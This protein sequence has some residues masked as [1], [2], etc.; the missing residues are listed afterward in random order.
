MW[1]LLQDLRF[2]LWPCSSS[3]SLEADGKT[4]KRF[5]TS[6]ATY[7]QNEMKKEMD[8]IRRHTKALEDLTAQLKT[9]QAMLK[10]LD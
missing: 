7:L 2:R 9:T 6:R 8:T 3:L 1:E 5:L 10:S 4:S